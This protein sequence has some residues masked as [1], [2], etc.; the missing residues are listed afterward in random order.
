MKKCKRCKKKLTGEMISN[1]DLCLICVIDE[2]AKNFNKKRNKE[3][4]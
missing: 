2:H 4:K 1:P 3:K